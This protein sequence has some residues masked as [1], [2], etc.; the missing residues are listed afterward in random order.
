M[1]PTTSMM[2]YGTKNAPEKQK[3]NATITEKASFDKFSDQDNTSE[4]YPLMHETWLGACLRSVLKQNDV[5]KGTEIKHY[6]WLVVIFPTYLLFCERESMNLRGRHRKFLRSQTSRNPDCIKAL[7]LVKTREL[8]LSAR[9]EI[10]IWINL[11]AL[12]LKNGYSLKAT[13]GFKSDRVCTFPMR[14]MGSGLAFT[15]SYLANSTHKIRSRFG[16]FPTLSS[17]SSNWKVHQKPWEFSKYSQK[18]RCRSDI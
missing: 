17:S 4:K 10:F 7:F 9:V 11:S 18:R 13:N 6:V 3:K 8:F 12:Q 16:F 5:C 2:Q 15:F 14:Q 1:P